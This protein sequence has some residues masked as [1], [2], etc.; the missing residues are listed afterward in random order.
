MRVKNPSS[1]P[2]LS[3]AILFRGDGAT[4]ATGSRNTFSMRKGE[5]IAFASVLESMFCLDALAAP[6]VY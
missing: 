2:P 5:P 4:L 1:H 6:V 3:T